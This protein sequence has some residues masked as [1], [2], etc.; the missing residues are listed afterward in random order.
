MEGEPTM[1]DVSVPIQMSWSQYLNIDWEK[2]PELKGALVT[3]DI[4]GNVHCSDWAF[5][6]LSRLVWAKA[7]ERPYPLSEQDETLFKVTRP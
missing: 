4:Y 1:K 3:L 5:E 6:G 7:N 2:I